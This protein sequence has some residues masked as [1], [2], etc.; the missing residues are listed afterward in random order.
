MARSG[1]KRRVLR[2][3]DGQAMIETVLSLPLLMLLLVGAAELARVAYAAIELTN[4]AR[5]G[6]Q[7][8]ATSPT[9]E[10]DKSGI[11]TAAENEAND[12]Y[13][14]NTSA[15]TVTPSISYI[16]SDGS[17]PTGTP[18]ACTGNNVVENI[19]TVTTSATFDPLFYAPVFGTNHTFTI[20]GMA[21]QK[22]LIQ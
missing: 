18:L 6:A 21:V 11:T 19:L 8:G 10:N 14:L 9:Y 17:A 13:K 4:A 20:T 2:E 1:F 12:I 16:C 7:Y 3:E 22:V 5:A 15:F